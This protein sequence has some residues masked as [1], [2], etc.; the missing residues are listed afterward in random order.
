MKIIL[1]INMYVGIAN[2]FDD[3]L[4]PLKFKIVKTTII[5]KTKGTLYSANPLNADIIASAP[6]LALTATVSI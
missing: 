5:I 1:N 6:A 3:S 2:I 4:I